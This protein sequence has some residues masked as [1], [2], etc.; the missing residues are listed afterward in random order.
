MK[1]TWILAGLVAVG[2][3][4]VAIAIRPEPPAR[5]LALRPAV[6]Q[7]RIEREALAR[8][9]GATAQVRLPNGETV[10]PSNE[11]HATAIKVKLYKKLLVREEEA[12]DPTLRLRAESELA[13]RAPRH[14]SVEWDD[15]SGNRELVFVVE[16]SSDCQLGDERELSL[17]PAEA[18]SHACLDRGENLW[19][20]ATSLRLQIEPVDE[21]VAAELLRETMK[22][23][24]VEAYLA[25]S[26][27]L[28]AA[29]SQ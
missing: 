7:S 23:L 22:A 27:L 13:R 4:A 17:T 15:P 24:A 19:N 2:L 28:P 8:F 21:Q 6:P 12:R 10:A 14:V 20:Q 26:Q 18:A 5:K 16:D 9:A 3:A 1:K 11:A 25:R 29:G